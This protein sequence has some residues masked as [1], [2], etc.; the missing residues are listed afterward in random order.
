MKTQKEIKGFDGHIILYCKYHYNHSKNPLED[1]KKIWSIRCGYPYNEKDNSAVK[2][3]INRLYKILLS[4]EI[5]SSSFQEQLH[6]HLLNWLYKEM[7]TIDK[8]IYFYMSK[9]SN[10]TINKQIGNKWITLIK[11]PKPKKRVFNRIIRGNGRYEDY[12]LIN[13]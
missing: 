13:S 2:P 7:S 3:I 10:I 8:L 1:L 12:K 11:L 5:D 9:I 6:D 4:T